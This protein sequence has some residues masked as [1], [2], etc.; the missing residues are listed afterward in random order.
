MLNALMQME[1][2]NLANQMKVFK[3]LVSGFSLQSFLSDACFCI[4]KIQ[5]DYFYDQVTEAI[6]FSKAAQWMPTT[7]KW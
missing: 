7:D 4:G 6:E 1:K 2:S 5:S 3:Q